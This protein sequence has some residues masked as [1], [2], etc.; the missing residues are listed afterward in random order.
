MELVTRVELARHAAAELADREQRYP[1]Q[2]AANRMSADTAGRRLAAWRMIVT[3]LDAGETRVEACFGADI[4]TAW[5]ELLEQVE[6]AV[7]HRARRCGTD[8]GA[9]ERLTALRHLRSMLIRSASRQ[10]LAITS[11]VLGKA[12]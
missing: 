10:G 6:A 9:G 8:P 4:R 11:P 5:R 12:A 1:L 2:V 7:D 3:L